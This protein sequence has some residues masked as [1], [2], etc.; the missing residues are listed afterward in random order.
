MDQRGAE[1]QS[2]LQYLPHKIQR[3]NKTK[4]STGRSTGAPHGCTASNA[5]EGFDP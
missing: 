3:R 1:H 5:V 4:V 2:A